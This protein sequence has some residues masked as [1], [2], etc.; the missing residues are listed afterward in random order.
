MVVWKKKCY[1][2]VVVFDEPLVL[3]EVCVGSLFVDGGRS[4][5][6]F[7]EIVAMATAQDG[8]EHLFGGDEQ[9]LVLLLAGRHRH[10]ELVGQRQ[11][12]LRFGHFVQILSI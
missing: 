7:F 5:D 1:P 10:F 3:A 11:K 2:S 4:D 9:F 8:D 12:D 6:E